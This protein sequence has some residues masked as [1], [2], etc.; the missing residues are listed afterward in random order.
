MSDVMKV[1]IWRL[2]LTYQPKAAIDH[3]PERSQQL[4]HY[5][6]KLLRWLDAG[7]AGAPPEPTLPSQ[8]THWRLHEQ[9]TEEIADHRSD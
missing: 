9:I 4:V 8:R 2:I 6:I 3:R 5:K 1:A 7:G